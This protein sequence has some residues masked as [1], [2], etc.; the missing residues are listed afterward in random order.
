MSTQSKIAAFIKANGYE[1]IANID[2]IKVAFFIPTMRNGQP[3]API[4]AEVSTFAE[5]RAQMGY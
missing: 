1:P 3:D 2:G 4:F 5:A